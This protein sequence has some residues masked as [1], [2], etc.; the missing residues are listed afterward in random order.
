MSGGA[1]PPARAYV[2]SRGGEQFLQIM[3]TAN[4]DVFNSLGA[5]ITV[6]A[7][8]PQSLTLTLLLTFGSGTSVPSSVRSAALTRGVDPT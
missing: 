2:N 5:G 7:F 6:D 8:D 3:A 4:A 1:W